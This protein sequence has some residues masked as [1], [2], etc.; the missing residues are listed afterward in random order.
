M[1]TDHLNFYKMCPIHSEFPTAIEA[2]IVHCLSIRSRKIS[3]RR[4]GDI[5]WW[6]LW[7]ALHKNQE[8]A[9]KWFFSRFLL[10]IQH[11]FLPKFPR[12]PAIHH[13]FQSK[14]PWTHANV[15]CLD[16]LNALSWP[17]YPIDFFYCNA[18]VMLSPI[19][20]SKEFHANSD[21]LPSC[22]SLP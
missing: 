17:N 8:P 1:V 4:L 10:N 11:L 5:I 3:A 16:M 20:Y 19:L 14:R 13:T 6:P 2:K 9:T 22:L 18:K 12:Y 15:W 7:V 21:Q